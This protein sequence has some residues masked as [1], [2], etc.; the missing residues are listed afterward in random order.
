M[1]DLT[2]CCRP[3]PPATTNNT[4][5]LDRGHGI[6][7]SRE[8][9]VNVKEKAVH[10]HPARVFPYKQHRPVHGFLTL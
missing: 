6:V 5:L 10:L 9:S 4:E 1:R 2:E 7:C 8:F 3:T